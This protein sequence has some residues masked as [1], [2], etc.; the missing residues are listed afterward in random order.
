RD[1]GGLAGHDHVEGLELVLRGG[2]LRGRGCARRRLRGGAD[3][4]RGRRDPDLGGGCGTGGEQS[5]EQGERLQAE[6]P[7]L[8]ASRNGRCFPF[9]LANS[10][11]V[12]LIAQSVCCSVPQAGRSSVERGLVRPFTYKA[13]P[14]LL[15]T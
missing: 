5:D 14:P 6:P 12:P 7:W 15:R 11:G 10:G 4:L 3:L 8:A 1:A 13:A 2:E 9:R